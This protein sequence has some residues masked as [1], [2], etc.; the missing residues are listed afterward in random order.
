MMTHSTYTRIHMAMD[1][2]VGVNTHGVNS[3]LL[4]NGTWS[5][6]GAHVKIFGLNC[7]FC[8]LVFCLWLQFWVWH[9]IQGKL[10]LLFLAD[11]AKSCYCT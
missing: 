7:G 9:F 2:T 4:I 1:Y 6:I 3:A 10:S 8:K 11:S 5:H